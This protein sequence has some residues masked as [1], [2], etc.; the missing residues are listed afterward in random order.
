MAVATG[1]RTWQPPAVQQLVDVAVPV[2]LGV[3]TVAQLV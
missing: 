3:L 1:R 2:L